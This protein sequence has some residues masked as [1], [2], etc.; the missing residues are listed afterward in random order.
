MIKLKKHNL[1]KKPLFI[2][3]YFINKNICT[4]L[5]TYFETHKEFHAEGKVYVK[6][7]QREGNDDKKSTD[8]SLEA[9]NGSPLIQNYL[10]ELSKAITLYKKQFP[11]CNDKHEVW[12][13]VEGFNIQRYKPGE[14]FYN[15]HY[16]RG[17]D[18]ISIKRHLVFMTYLNTVKSGGQTS[19]YHQ[20]LKINAE[21]GLT[22]IWPAEWTY[23]HKGIPSSKETKYIITGWWSYER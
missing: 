15:W 2:K 18:S 1:N 9:E 5:I 4:D 16:E 21:K 7:G 11:Y 6:D 12:S 23:L 13:V 19:F 17:Q 22:V 3:G 8:L 20:K 14:G 10:Y